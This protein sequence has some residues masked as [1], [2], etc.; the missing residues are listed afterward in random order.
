VST[1]R[2]ST[3]SMEVCAI[4]SATS[5]VIASFGP[6][7]VSPVSGSTTSCDRDAPE[8]AVRQ[9]LDDVLVVLQRPH[10]HA[11]DGAAVVLR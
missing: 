3:V 9:R 8:D 11:A 6:T 5:S 2:I 1:E 7:M 4:A 10:L